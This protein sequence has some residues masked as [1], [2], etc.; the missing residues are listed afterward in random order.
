MSRNSELIVGATV[1]LAGLGLGA[2]YA[3]SVRQDEKN[4]REARE[5]AME[6]AKQ[7]HL[8]QVQSAIHSF[9]NLQKA[10]AATNGL[11]SSLG[12]QHNF[13]IHNTQVR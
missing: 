5:R 4:Q 11:L 13:N 7:R 1:L 2:Y 3:R 10:D 6:A 8:Q 12:Q 9:N